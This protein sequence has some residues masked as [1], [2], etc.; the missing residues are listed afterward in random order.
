MDAKTFLQVFCVIVKI[1]SSIIIG[2]R[3]KEFHRMKN[4]VHVGPINRRVMLLLS[5]KYHLFKFMITY[6][7]YFD[8]Y[9]VCKLVKLL[10]SFRK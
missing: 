6:A 3:Y 1:I 8:Q 10:V 5:I 4:A 2:L 9:N 7:H